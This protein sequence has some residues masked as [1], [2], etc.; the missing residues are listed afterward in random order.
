M[1][2][3]SPLPARVHASRSGAEPISPGTPRRRPWRPVGIS[4]LVVAPCSSRSTAPR[5]RP[6]HARAPRSS[7]GALRPVSALNGVGGPGFVRTRLPSDH[8]AP[9]QPRPPDLSEWRG[10]IAFSGA[11]F[12]TAPPPRRGPRRCPPVHGLRP[13]GP[14]HPFR[15]PNARPEDLSEGRPRRSRTTQTPSRPLDLS[16]WSSRPSDEERS[17]RSKGSPPGTE[18][19]DLRDAA[20]SGIPVR[21]QIRR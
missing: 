11:R 5:H 7:L 10:P 8:E 14:N 13:S 6:I 4:A 9:L 18:H 2:R 3:R 21:A 17:L 12:Q 15:P 16:E 20:R 1:S 19:P